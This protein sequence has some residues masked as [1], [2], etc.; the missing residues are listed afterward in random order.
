MDFDTT[1]IRTSGSNFRIH[2]KHVPFDFSIYSNIT[3]PDLVR[4]ITFQSTMAES[5]NLLSAPLVR[6]TPVVRD[7]QENYQCSDIDLFPQY[8]RFTP[9]LANT[10]GQDFIT[11]YRLPFYR[12]RLS[13]VL[14]VVSWPETEDF[15]NICKV[16]SCKNLNGDRYG[17]GECAWTAHAEQ[18]KG[19][20]V[21]T[22]PPRI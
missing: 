2:S 20:G 19:L 8:G 10:T 13:R 14:S 21:G 7:C 22:Y 6:T 5:P 4:L 15:Y 12:I 17:M 16:H 11:I 3:N 9:D 1:Y 18:R